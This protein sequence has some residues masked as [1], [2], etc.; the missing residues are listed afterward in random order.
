VKRLL[1]LL[2]LLLSPLRA[3]ETDALADPATLTF[4]N[5][6]ITTFRATIAG[7]T[8]AERVE[9]TVDRMRDLHDYSLYEPVTFEPVSAGDL[10]GIAFEID[11]KRLF[12]LIDADL[13]PTSEATL[14]E[15]AE[16][17]RERLEEIRQAWLDQRS[18]GVI[19]RGVLLSLAATGVFA[20]SLLA[21]LRLSRLARRFFVRRAAK[22]R[23]L[24]RHDFDLRP[25]LLQLNRRIVGALFA[26]SVFALAYLWLTFVLGRFPYTAPWSD[27]LGERLGVLG[28]RLLDSLLGALP[29]LLVVILI[30]FVTRGAARIVDQLLAS[31]EKSEEE[32]DVFGK[33][34][35]RATRRIAG[36][37]I[38]I[39]GIVI[40]YPYIPGSDSP[41]FKGIGVLL[42]LMVSIGSSGFINQLMSGFSVLY[43]GAV[44][45]GEF[46][47]VGEIEGRITDI[48]L[49]STRLRTPKHEFVS[50][51]N[52]VLVSKET[53]NYSR[54]D[55]GR[56]CELSTSVTIGYD[57]PWRQ[58]EQ[59]LLEAADRTPNIRDKPEPHVLQTALSDFYAEYELRFVPGDVTRKSR[60]LADLHQRIQDAFHEAG[61]QIMSPH[62]ESQP[63][64][65]V[66]PP[67]DEPQ[68]KASSG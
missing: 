66:L 39:A 47:R 29:G 65:P 45:S 6:E 36:I 26:L 23:K 35:A 22:I 25:V 33:D 64:Q 57:A 15:E 50:I 30:F 14:E 17:V 31:F 54:P 2:L 37:A 38:W 32:D 7:M 12:S 11:D 13:D 46:I 18:A 51:P 53:H 3:A 56:H 16:R 8:P 1:G 59:L 34:T 61:L 20:L 67:P 4:W 28:E 60:I 27:V 49:L 24:K 55:G 21:L 40:A 42:G 43:S 62:F 41:A 44:R 5:R 10:R 9:E 52:A 68:S 63:D 58:V 19:L 48:G